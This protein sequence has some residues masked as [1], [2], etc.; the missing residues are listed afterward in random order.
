MESDRLDENCVDFSAASGVEF[1]END[2]FYES[3]AMCSEK[4]L[5][6]YLESGVVSEAS[7]RAVIAERKV[8]PC[9]FGSA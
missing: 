4:L 2:D 7:I 1:H 8:F 9:C 3:I 6:E 5:E